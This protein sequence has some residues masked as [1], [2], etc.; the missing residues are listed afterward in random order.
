M[1]YIITGPVNSGKSTHLASIYDKLQKGDGFYMK[2][3]F[4]GSL[5]KGQEI[6]R[7]ATKAKIP[8]SYITK[9]IP[10]NWDEAYQYK[11]YSFSRS[12]LKF[13]EDIFIKNFNPAFLDELG[14][15]ELA[16][17]GFHEIFNKLLK[18]DKDIYTVVRYECLFEIIDKFNIIDYVIL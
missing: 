1:I 18:T 14:P 13:A 10:E 11:N 5:Y 8:F 17:G 7:L 3:I 12:A 16:G 2:K 6:I 15:I 9:Y 4:D